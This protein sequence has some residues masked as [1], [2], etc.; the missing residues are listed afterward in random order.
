M[1][2]LA[3]I[4]A[5]VGHLIAGSSEIADGTFQSLPWESLYHESM[6]T[7]WS[8]F[9]WSWLQRSDPAAFQRSNELTYRCP[10]SLTV[11]KIHQWLRLIARIHQASRQPD[12]SATKRNPTGEPSTANLHHAILPVYVIIRRSTN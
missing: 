6:R 7:N 8:D 10:S 4:W 12:P 1:P 3:F 2:F 11:T 5:A 9:Q